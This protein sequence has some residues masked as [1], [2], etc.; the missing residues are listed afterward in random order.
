M[1]ERDGLRE[2]EN[3]K[4]SN[5]NGWLLLWTEQLVAALTIPLIWEGY[6][7]SALGWSQYNGVPFGA[8]GTQI[9]AAGAIALCS[10]AVAYLISIVSSKA[11]QLGIW[12]WVL[13][14]ASLTI[15][16]LWEKTSLNWTAIGNEFFFWSHPGLDEGIVMRDFF[17]YPAWS[18]SCFSTAAAIIL[19][20]RHK[21]AL[22]RK[23]ATAPHL[24]G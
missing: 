20:A 18:S 1:P 13:P 17:T 3:R 2:Q 9:A 14:V 4:N 23:G 5:G 16:M 10:V 12:V 22:R 15:A 6:L 24:G 21:I 11:C 8:V 7:E 19:F